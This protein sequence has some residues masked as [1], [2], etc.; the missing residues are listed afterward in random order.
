MGQHESQYI[1]TQSQKTSVL[2]CLPA[3]R[4]ASAPL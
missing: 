2:P 4:S 3:G 1:A